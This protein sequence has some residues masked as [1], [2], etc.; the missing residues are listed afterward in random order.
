MKN[1]IWINAIATVKLRFD[2]PVY[3]DKLQ[4]GQNGNMLE[5]KRTQN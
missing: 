5:I 4:N 3:Y 2:G 1:L